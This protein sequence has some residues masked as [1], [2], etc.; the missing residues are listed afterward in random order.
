MDRKSVVRCRA[1]C[2]FALLNYGSPCHGPPSPLL[3]RF[4][5][6][7]SCKVSIVGLI[8]GLSILHRAVF[9]WTVDCVIV[10]KARNLCSRLLRS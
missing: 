9:H 6:S 3:Q 5:R 7:C 4:F 8:S 2:G 1:G 10:A